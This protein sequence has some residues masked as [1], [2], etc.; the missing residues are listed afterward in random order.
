M[1]TKFLIDY[2]KTPA[3]YKPRSVC[4]WFAGWVIFTEL[5]TIAAIYGAVYRGVL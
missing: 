3:D 1:E 5:V 4:P 2:A